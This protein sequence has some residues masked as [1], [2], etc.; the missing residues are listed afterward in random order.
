MPPDN[1]TNG[2]LLI[3]LF[4]EPALQ[5]VSSELYD[6]IYIRKAEIQE[7]LCIEEVGLLIF[8]EENALRHSAQRCAAATKQC[9]A[10]QQHAS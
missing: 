3:T 8:L 6:T 2:R 10:Y 9:S 1:C 7:L 4:G 5:G